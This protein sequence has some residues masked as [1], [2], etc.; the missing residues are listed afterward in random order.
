MIDKILGRHVFVFAL[1]ALSISP[2]LAGD[3]VKGRE[4]YIEYCSG[5]HGLEGV[6][7]VGEIPNFS[8]GQ[9]LN[10]SDRDLLIYMKK[11]SDIMPAYEGVLTDREILDVI[12]HLRTLF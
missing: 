6:P 5:C 8:L 1:M 10:K 12:A 4:I 11:G 9:G 2:A 7:Q 3:P